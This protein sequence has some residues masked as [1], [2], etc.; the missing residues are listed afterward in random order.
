MLNRTIRDHHEA[1]H[2]VI[3]DFRTVTA[4]AAVMRRNEHIDPPKQF[5]N[6]RIAKKLKPS[7]ALKVA[8]KRE[9]YI[10]HLEKD[11]KTQ[12]VSIGELRI[13]VVKHPDFQ[14]CG[15]QTVRRDRRGIR[16]NHVE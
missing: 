16:I 4:L 11:K 9:Q 12:V 10:P 5:L 3:E 6:L 1:R 13:V 15:L 8:A 2:A 14:A 7:S